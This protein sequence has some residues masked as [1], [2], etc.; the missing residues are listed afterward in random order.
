MNSEKTFLEQARV[1]AKN[2]DKN[3]DELAV[4]RRSVV[5]RVGS[6][7]YHRYLSERKALIIGKCKDPVGNEFAV[8]VTS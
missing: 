1:V 7:S 5:V 4:D 8:F 2:M 3:E 6:A